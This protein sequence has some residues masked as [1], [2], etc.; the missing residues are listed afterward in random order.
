MW[1]EV[2]QHNHCSESLFCSLSHVAILSQVAPSSQK[3]QSLDALQ[4]QGLPLFLY[5]Y[6]QLQRHKCDWPQGCEASKLSQVR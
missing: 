2:W 3:I 6:V 5:G 1:P 4:S